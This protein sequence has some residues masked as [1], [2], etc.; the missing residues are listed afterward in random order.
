MRVVELLSAL[1]AGIR[2]SDVLDV[3]VVGALIY[4]LL[5][6]LS[7]ARARA[8]LFLLG[9]VGVVHLVARAFGL[10]LSSMLL[11]AGLW[12]VALI[13]VIA[14]QDDLRRSL[15]RIT[16]WRVLGGRGNAGGPRCEDLVESV[17]RMAEKRVGALI[18]V[19]GHESLNPHVM[20]GLRL[21]GRVSGPLLE[22]I[23]SPDSPGHDG[24]VIVDNGIIP[25]FGVHLPL[26]RRAEEN[27]THG[28]RHTA[29]IALSE[30]CDA[31][32]IVVSEE[33]GEIS[34]AKNG[35]LETNVDRDR[36]SQ[37][38]CE[39]GSTDELR[40]RRRF[41]LH[42]VVWRASV[43][44]GL[45]FLLWFALV[46]REGTVQQTLEVP[47]EYRNVPEELALLEPKPG[48]VKVTVAGRRAA[49]EDLSEKDLTAALDLAHARPG[50]HRLWIDRDDVSAPAT[51]DVLQVDPPTVEVRVVKRRR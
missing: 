36:L 20:G 31:L 45:S 13:A 2:W 43:A 23:F 10:H 17:V 30:R 4:F 48:Q 46:F 27:T 1:P 15:H 6:S 35:V 51:L 7:R 24:A 25:R 28:T 14:F 19:P 3:F 18:V 8:F 41:A 9:G 38:I 42:R 21:E 22:S 29:A 34:V 44:L 16:A 33:R 39:H 49:F 37:H 40:R 32:V 11:G 50:D 47:L 26:S 12:I 5:S